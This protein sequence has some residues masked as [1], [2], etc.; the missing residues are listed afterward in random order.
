MAAEPVQDRSRSKHDKL[1]RAAI[2]LLAEGGTRA[3]THRAVAERAGVAPAS[4]TYY[5][6]SIEDLTNQAFARHVSF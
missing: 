4:T 1:L 2:E 6:R 5:F 3:V